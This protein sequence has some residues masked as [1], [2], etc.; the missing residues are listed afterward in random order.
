MSSA[1]LK[2]KGGVAHDIISIRMVVLEG[3]TLDEVVAL[4]DMFEARFTKLRANPLKTKEEWNRCVGLITALQTEIIRLL[5]RDI[6]IEENKKIM[7]SQLP[8]K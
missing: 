1:R 2:M 6:R 8:E 5:A 7:A 4:R 3:M